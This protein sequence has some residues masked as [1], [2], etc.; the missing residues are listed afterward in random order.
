[1]SDCPIDIST[2]SVLGS[3]H[4]C[5]DLSYSYNSQTIFWPSATHEKFQL[6]INCSTDDNGLFYAAGEFTCCEHGGTHV[7]A[8]Y[9][10]SE[11][12]KTVDLIPL[13]D[14][15]GNVKL[16]D[17]TSQC[18]ENRDYEL[19]VDD[20]LQFEQMHGKLEK[21][22][23]VLIRTGWH[24][25]WELGAVAYLGFDETKETYDPKTSILSFPG[26]G[27]AAAVML[28]ERFVTA[29]GLDTPSLD[30]GS[31]KEFATHRILLEKGIYGI[32]NLNGSIMAVPS[33]GATAIVMPMKIE[34]GTGAPSRV[35]V[36]Y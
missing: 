12:G 21:G 30:P 9:H 25:N 23:I 34:G 17:I 36:L 15:I 28:T 11:N 32:E 5:V 18:Q 10:F 35:L 6:C 31:N 13:T 33:I 2:V 16:I 26:I 1:M 3:T 8:P 29:V 4:N 27:A 14:L 7:D 19:Q 20:I 22:D 24:K